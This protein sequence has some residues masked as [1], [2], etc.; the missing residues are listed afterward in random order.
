[1]MKDN[2][3]N[4][5]PFLSQ[6]K[7][8]QELVNQPTP[9]DRWADSFKQLGSQP[10]NSRGQRSYNAVMQG[11][12]SGVQGAEDRRRQEKL[13]PILE[14]AGQITAK[15]A[16]L[17]AQSQQERQR[18]FTGTKFVR[19][20]ITRLM[21]LGDGSMAQDSVGT[22]GVARELGR[23]YQKAFGLKLGEFDHYDA[24]SRRIYYANDGVV[25]GYSIPDILREYATEAFG[26]QA[27]YVM[28][29]LDP[30][31]KNVWENTQALQKAELGIKQ[32]TANVNNA[33]ADNF[34]ALTEKTQHEMKN[35]E[36]PYNKELAN[37]NLTYIKEQRD[38]NTNAKALVATL[39]DLEGMIKDANKKGQAGST[40]KTTGNRL[41]AKYL[42]GDNESATLADMA[43][44]AYFARVKE[45]GGS[46]PSTTEFLTVLETV[47][48]IDK[49]PQA[50]LKRLQ[51]DRE[52]AL[53]TMYR[54]K[55]TEEGLRKTKYQGSPD[56]EAVFK[57]NDDEYKTFSKQYYTPKVTI[58]A[59]DGTIAS[60]SEDHV[61]ELIKKGG[62][63]I[64]E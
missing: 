29:T 43:K 11:F 2:F 10:A 24:S 16:E 48:N 23:D 8:Y 42:S 56:D 6:A 54:Y 47:P 30:Y 61:D 17:E 34:K 40:L 25:T 20:N 38:R 26:E 36:E 3:S 46:N 51:F 37:H 1:M 7:Q 59:P 60:V 57:H 9:S 31:S 13:S 14:Q 15:A 28:R 53:K 44:A 64:D 22:Q 55:K 41:W 21:A 12:A 58:Q 18:V 63:V 39:N 27:P 19:D 4:P 33:H 49:N 32:S 52:Q 50:A 62:K 45:G 35:P 5:N